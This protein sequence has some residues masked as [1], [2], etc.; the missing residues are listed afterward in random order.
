MRK[1]SL[2][3]QL[4]FYSFLVMIALIGSV[5]TFYYR[6]SSS[7]ISQLTEQKTRDS[8]QQSGHFITAYL[9][10]LKQTSNSLASNQLLR[11]FIEQPDQ[12][13]KE[14]L[15]FLMESLIA[16]DTDLVSA[17][18][19]TK[20]GQIVSTDKQLVMKT[21]SD[22]M[23][24]AWY[25]A[26]IDQKAMPVLT[27]ARKESLTKKGEQWVISVTREIVDA[28]GKNKGV[29]RLDIDYHSLENYLDQ[30][31]L[32][33]QGFAFI[34]NQ[35]KEFVY[36]PQKTVYSSKEEM[37]A[38]K[39]YLQ[40]EN[41]YVPSHKEFVYQLAIPESEWTLVGVSSL[42]EVQMIRQQILYSFLGAG[43]AALVISGLGSALVIRIW[44]K[45]I[46]DLQ[47]VILAIG[48]G[49]A[50]LRAKEAGAAEVLDL[51]RYFNKMLDQIDSLML[52]VK[53]QEQD[54][55]EYELMALASQIN[56]HFLYNTLD[57]IIWMTEFNDRERV[58]EIT[59]ALAKYFRIALNKGNEQI[60]LKD[61]LEHVGQYLFIQQQRYGDK[62]QYDLQELPSYADYQLPKLVLQPIVE[63]A[64]YHGIKEVERK[65]VITIRVSETEKHLRITIH[66]NG[67]GMPTEDVITQSDKKVHQGGIGLKNVD[68]RLALQFGSAYHMEIK[69]EPDAFTEISLFLPRK[70]L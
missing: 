61:E 17:V 68:Q 37:D 62:L 53:K 69:S 49:Q 29:L 8:L 65:G 67:K 36:H 40:V 23:S 3:V 7:A 15:S 20:E 2:A 45:P 60:S 4:F 18:L 66:D 58:V 16:G 31:K 41:G 32:G 46:R 70:S 11:D 6:T 25:Q 47:Q 42:D 48:Q 5:G 38:M 64:I 24:E 57:T 26:A 28:R 33:K 50:H 43:L 54:I 10:K 9:D 19:V 52:S 13:H 59:K 22:M 30:L 39:S 35:K 21:S 27:P 55:R 1:Y 56:P 51:S 14:E 34:V 12:A 63:N 44:L